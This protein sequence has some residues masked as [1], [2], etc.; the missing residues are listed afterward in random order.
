MNN[1]KVYHLSIVFYMI[2]IGSSNLISQNQEMDPE[3]ATQSIISQFEMQ[4]GFIPKPL[5]LLSERSGVVPNFMK[6]G[7]S[8]T[9][10]G[11]LTPRE[12]NL[13]TLSAA[14]ALK[15]PECIRNQIKKLKKTDVSDEEIMQVVMLAAVLGN[16][17]TLSDAFDTL[18]EET[19]IQK[20]QN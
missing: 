10:G 14:V 5:L 13:I 8:L 17:T 7:S 15:S 16:T 3:K 1:K 20:D 6:Y 2:I 4:Y 9:I 12:I 18:K 19:V 11:P